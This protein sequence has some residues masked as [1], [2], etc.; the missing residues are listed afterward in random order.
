MVCRREIHLD[1]SLVDKMVKLRALLLALQKADH[2][3]HLLA[4]PMVIQKVALSEM[5]TDSHLGCLL[6]DSTA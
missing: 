3:E 1:C 2:L 5:M 6:A 4:G